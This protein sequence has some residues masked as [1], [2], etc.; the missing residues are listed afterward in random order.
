MAAYYNEF[1][2]EAAHML[3]Q[4]IKD[5]LIADGEVDERS[6]T[7][8][9]AEDLKGFTQCHFFGG[10]GGWSV[11][12]RQAMWPDD[13]PVWT[14]SCPCQPFSSAGKQKGK[15]DA[16]H[17]WPVWFRLI[18]ESRPPVVFGEQVSAAI[19]HGWW[20]DVAD[21]LEGEGYTTRAEIRPASSVGRPHKRDRLWFVADSGSRR[22]DEQGKG[23]IQ[24]SR[25]AETFSAGIV[26][27]S[28]HDGRH[29]RPLTGSDGTTIPDDAQGANGT[30]ESTGAGESGDVAYS[31]EQR[32]QRRELL[33]ERASERVAGQDGL[34]WLACPDG[35]TRPVKSG[36]CL[37]AHGVQHRA[38]LLHGYGNAIVPAVAAAFIKT[39]GLI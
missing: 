11:A 1:K 32:P 9:R 13:R 37:L 23:E 7:D 17:L 16:R 15:E 31:N 28:E 34:E 29:G 14:G 39:T 20:D 12:L 25:G 4:L 33:S 18:R 30:S 2:P 10:V 6:I 8:V 36:L 24:Q 5:G 27:Y 38:P 21:D 3:R 35:K 22:R 19:R 26:G